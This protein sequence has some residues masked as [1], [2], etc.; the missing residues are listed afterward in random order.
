[1]S[2]NQTTPEAARAALLARCPPYRFTE[3]PWDSL[4]PNPDCRASVANP[5]ETLECLRR[6]F[7]D[8]ILKEAGLLERSSE[9]QP[10]L[11]PPLCDPDGAVL[12]L[13]R[14]PGGGVFD[15]LTNR[16]CLANRRLPVFVSWNDRLNFA[17]FIKSRVLFAASDIRDVALLRALGLPAT[18]STG[19]ERAT[20]KD[21]RTLHQAF[22]DVPRCE[23]PC[24]GEIEAA[25]SAA[26]HVLGA[27]LDPAVSPPTLVLL[28]WQIRS[29]RPDLPPT[30]PPVAARL[31]GFDLHLGVKPAQA[32]VWRPNFWEL[33]K[34]AFY[35]DV[36]PPACYATVL[37][38]NLKDQLYTVEACA[39]PEKAARV[40]TDGAP[41][42]VVEVRARLLE[43][44]KE[45][46]GE[47]RISDR[48]RKAQAAYEALTRRDLIEPLE[49]WALASA[50][51]LLRNL[52]TQLAN[53]CALLHQGAPALHELQARDLEQILTRGIV[54]AKGGLLQ[55]HMQLI[56]RL[57]N[58]L[59]Q[60]GRLQ[61][62]AP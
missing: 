52:G 59:T 46:R 37:L 33:D 14:H 15:L 57:A 26:G 22:K 49:R 48:T 10:R 62:G 51:P 38:T 21:F 32:A 34:I 58:L 53:V 4:P 6:A 8:A 12:A 29:L 27:D 20:L 40:G 23:S 56:A 36:T 24:V 9:G 13:R 42:D 5:E 55:Q 30:V 18:L 39:D 16:G 44:L 25:L 11:A 35:L 2:P 3:A 43:Q 50:D 41:A 60:L 17:R 45:D 7:P 31:H 61:K 1:M 19:L 28:G 47:R 54:P